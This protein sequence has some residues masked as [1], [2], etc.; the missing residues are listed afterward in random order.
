MRSILTS[1][2]AEQSST[3]DVAVSLFP[4]TRSTERRTDEELIRFFVGRRIAGKV[5]DR[6][7]KAALSNAST[8]A[9]TMQMQVAIDESIARAL[10]TS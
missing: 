4:K 7:L 5:S 8:L 9:G 3:A 2:Q 10:A 6:I 1:Q